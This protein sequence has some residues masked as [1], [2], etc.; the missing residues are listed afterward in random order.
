M[1]KFVPL[2]NFFSAESAWNET[3][4]PSPAQNTSPSPNSG[5]Y[6][7]TVKQRHHTVCNPH[8]HDGTPPKWPLNDKIKF[9]TLSHVKMSSLIKNA[10]LALSIKMTIF[11]TLNQSK[12]EIA[13]Q[14]LNYIKM[15]KPNHYEILFKS[16]YALWSTRLGNSEKW[17]FFKLGL[18]QGLNEGLVALVSKILL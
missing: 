18:N 16:S 1:I 4:F 6:T 3:F 8:Y 11:L 13:Q 12:D 14:E 7:T 17:N 5:W 10:Y 2:F 15:L 9:L